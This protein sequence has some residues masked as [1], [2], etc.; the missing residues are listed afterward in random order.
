MVSL[1]FSGHHV[2]LSSLCAIAITGV[3]FCLRLKQFIII[4]LNVHQIHLKFDT[5]IHLGHPITLP[6]STRLV[7]YSETL[8]SLLCTFG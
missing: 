5:G 6:I 8:K 1:S 2:H 3:Q 7:L 4:P